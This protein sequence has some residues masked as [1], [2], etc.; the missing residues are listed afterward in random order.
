MQRNACA[1]CA[2]ADHDKAEVKGG[3][4]NE[5]KE[6]FCEHNEADH[7]LYNLACNICSEGHTYIVSKHLYVTT[8]HGIFNGANSI[9]DARLRD[10][11]KR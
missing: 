7:A 11:A 6:E 1:F 4:M 10:I 2:D 5:P 9:T 8:K 3:L